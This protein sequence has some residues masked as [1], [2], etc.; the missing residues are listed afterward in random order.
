[1]NLHK[2]MVLHFGEE[3]VLTLQ[4]P[5][6]Y[7]AMLESI[8]IISGQLMEIIDSFLEHEDIWMS[9]RQKKLLLNKVFTEFDTRDMCDTHPSSYCLPHSNAV[10]FDLKH[11]TVNLR[12]FLCETPE[13]IRSRIKKYK[14]ERMDKAILSPG[15]CLDRVP[16]QCVEEALDILEEA[17]GRLVQTDK[18]SV[19][20]M[21]GIM[22]LCDGFLYL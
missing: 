14:G 11:Q 1:M 20:D 22:H 15:F 9:D 3:P 21:T 17:D 6:I 16:F 2:T 7:P 12:C 19:V 13:V 5:L 18:L 4:E 10:C 8:K